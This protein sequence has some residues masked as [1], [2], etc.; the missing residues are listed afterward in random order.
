MIQIRIAGWA[1]QGLVLAGSI[2][3]HAYA[4][5][6]NKNVVTTRSYTAAVRSGITYSDIIV[7][8]HEIYDLVITKPQALIV[9]YQKTMDKFVSLAKKSEYLIVEKNL[10]PNV[11]DIPGK[12]VRVPAYD[13]AN[14]ENSPKMVNMVM[15]G[16]FAKSTN[17]IAIDSLI[18]SIDQNVSEKFRDLNKKLIMLGYE[19][20]IQYL[21]KSHRISI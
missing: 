21:N 8:D 20:N 3:A 9:L 13:I 4:M 18:K 19:Q 1:G 10:V 16:A 15:L 2:L 6:E 14:Q 12:T 11:P 5:H 7:D 17:L